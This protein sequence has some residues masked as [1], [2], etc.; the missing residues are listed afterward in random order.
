MTVRRIP[1][2][3]PKPTLKFVPNESNP[4]FTESRIQAHAESL[5]IAPEAIVAVPFSELEGTFLNT[6]ETNVSSGGQPVTMDVAGDITVIRHDAQA[7]TELGEQISDELDSF[8][9]ITSSEVS[10]N[11]MA[12]IVGVYEAESSPTLLI[13]NEHEMNQLE[14]TA[15]G[16][17]IDG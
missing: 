6:A 11:T 4:D 12:H 7:T 8:D 2:E 16:A 9:P 14:E 15:K 17:D 3:I 1:Q 10:K 5:N 13:N